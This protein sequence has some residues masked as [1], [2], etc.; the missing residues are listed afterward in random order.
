MF[1]VNH[2]FYTMT[3]LPNTQTLTMRVE[4]KNNASG[5]YFPVRIT[6]T[7][8]S[9]SRPFREFTKYLQA[10]KETVQLYPSGKIIERPLYIHACIPPRCDEPLQE[11]TVH[12][13]HCASQYDQNFISFMRASPE[14][15]TV[16][17]TASR[18]IAHHIRKPKLLALGMGSHARLGESSP[19]RLLDQGTLSL[20][21]KYV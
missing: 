9:L 6:G 5:I 19:F 14:V 1:V 10:S 13:R 7:E 3:V 12:F 21:A 11:L 20:V 15:E 17:R 4:H 2:P 8:G 18:I 16:L